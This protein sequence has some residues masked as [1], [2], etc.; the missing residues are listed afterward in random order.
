MFSVIYSL[1]LFG[2]AIFA[3]TGALVAERQQFNI[4]G[5]FVSAILTAVGGGTLR[6]IVLGETPVFWIQHP[7]YLIVAA[8]AGLSVFMIPPDRFQ[9]RVFLLADALGLAVFT[10]IGIQKA[11]SIDVPVFT[12][13][14]LGTVTAVGG[15]VIRDILI[16]HQSPIL[17]QQELYATAAF[18]GGWIYILLYL[19]PFPSLV[20][21]LSSI[22][23]VLLVRLAAIHWKLRLPIFQ[24]QATQAERTAQR[25]SQ[26]IR[27]QKSKTTRQKQAFSK[28]NKASS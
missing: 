4:L 8:L 12:A 24:I 5:I 22:L 15:G 6:D 20:A 9:T 21:V 11:I 13:V 10:I 26:K 7:V 18:L 17:L 28:R 27:S 25:K 16:G 2:V 19:S 1:D 3:I 14:L 23:V